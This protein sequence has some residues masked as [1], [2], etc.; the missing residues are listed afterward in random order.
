MPSTPGNATSVT[1]K[2]AGRCKCY[3]GGRGR[4]G[5]TCMATEGGLEDKRVR[6]LPLALLLR[7][8]QAAF[9][10]DG[11]AQVLRLSSPWWGDLH[12]VVDFQF[13]RVFAQ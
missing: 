8:R 7:W 12:R 9:F 5:K 13:G 10:S 4:V 2:V 3:D 11:L 6:Q 1:E